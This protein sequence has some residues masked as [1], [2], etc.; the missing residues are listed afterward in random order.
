M[1]KVG[2][3]QAGVYIGHMCKH[4]LEDVSTEAKLNVHEHN[5]FCIIRLK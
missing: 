3:D 2:V 4:R 1:W 5:F